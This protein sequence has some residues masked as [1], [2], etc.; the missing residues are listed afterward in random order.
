[1]SELRSQEMS[2]EELKQ[3]LS[4]WDSSAYWARKRARREHPWM[5]DLIAILYPRPNGLTMEQLL[6]EL[7]VIREKALPMPK[8]L[9]ETV[10]SIL[11]N[12]TSQ[13]AIFQKRLAPVDDDIFYSPEG[14]GSGTWAV[15]R[16]R[17]VVWLSR[18]ALC[19]I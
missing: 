9:R 19:S 1:M 13:S 10:Q 5:R 4:A 15:N 6:R 14:K 11:N 8:K 18:K 17:A 12:Y 3:A 16:D 7:E 2:L